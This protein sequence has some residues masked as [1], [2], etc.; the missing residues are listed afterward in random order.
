MMTAAPPHA[1]PSE[2]A[3]V[4]RLLEIAQP[5]IPR[6]LASFPCTP[7]P[8]DPLVL[9]LGSIPD[10]ARYFENVFAALPMPFILL[11]LP[12]GL[13]AEHF[14]PAKSPDGDF[15]ADL[16]ATVATAAPGDVVCVVVTP[17]TL[18]TLTLTLGTKCPDTPDTSIPINS[19]GGRA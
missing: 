15:V 2:V 17:E 13:A 16:R 12:L 1:P 7:D 9:V 8:A 14:A 18:H 11:A 19:R 10:V 4:A 5:H 3:H 6:A